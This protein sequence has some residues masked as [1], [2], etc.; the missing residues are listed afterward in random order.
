MYS[1]SSARLFKGGRVTIAPSRFLRKRRKVL[2]KTPA[3]G[4]LQVSLAVGEFKQELLKTYNAVNKEIFHG[5]VRQQNVELEGNR[6]I[7]LSR[8]G[9]APVLKTLDSRVPDITGYLD[10]ML[11][12]IFKERIKEELEKRFKLHITAIFKDYDAATETSGTVIYLEHDFQSC[13]NELSELP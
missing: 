10:Y 9:R 6:I 7:I 4:V 2:K 13:L 8:N 1:E 11:A 3:K 5:G 12:Q